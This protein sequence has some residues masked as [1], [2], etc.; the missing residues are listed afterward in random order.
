MNGYSFEQTRIPITEE[1]FVLSLDE[2]GPVVLD[3]FIS[4]MCV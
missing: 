2:T 4:L 1:C 3:F